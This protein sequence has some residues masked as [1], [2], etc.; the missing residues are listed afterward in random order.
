MVGT[1]FF[2]SSLKFIEINV[3]VNLDLKL[4]YV[5]AGL[6]ERPASEQKKNNVSVNGWS[7]QLPILIGVLFFILH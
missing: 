5:S 3:V 7:W 2:V 6:S 4:V 1:T